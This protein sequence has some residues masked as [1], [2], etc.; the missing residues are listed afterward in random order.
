MMNKKNL[1]YRSG[2]RWGQRNKKPIVRPPGLK[3]IFRF[4][5]HPPPHPLAQ[6]IACTFPD[7]AAATLSQSNWLPPKGFIAKV[8]KRGP[9]SLTW[10]E[11]QH[12]HGVIHP[13]L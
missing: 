5:I 1:R 10:T 7:T 12:P 8:N 11:P 9:A 6:H 13:V 4:R 3:T 2:E